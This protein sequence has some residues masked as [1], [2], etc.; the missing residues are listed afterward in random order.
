MTIEVK[1]HHR[2]I[3]DLA[4]EDNPTNARVDSYKN[5]LGYRESLAQ[6]WIVEVPKPAGHGM[7]FIITPAG[8]N[9]RYRP[10]SKAP[11]RASLRMIE[12]R[13]PTLPD[14]IQA[15]PPRLR[16]AD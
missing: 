4:A 8:Q 7:Y 9:A 6:G 10:K 3:L 15:A 2:R 13:I 11:K 5:L 14:R 12:P 16:R 1:A